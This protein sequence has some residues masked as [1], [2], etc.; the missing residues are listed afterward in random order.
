MLL[1]NKMT[2]RAYSVPDSKDEEF[3][4]SNCDCSSCKKMHDSQVEWDSFT[5][6]TNIQRR[7]KEAIARIEARERAR[8]GCQ[9]P[10]PRR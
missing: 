10:D 3:T 7:M 2:T 9:S 1:K 5:P 4:S 6:R 8:L